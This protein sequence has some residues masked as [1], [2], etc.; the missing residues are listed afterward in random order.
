MTARAVYESQYRARRCRAKAYAAGRPVQTWDIVE[1]VLYGV[2]FKAANN[3]NR[4]FS[5]RLAASSEPL[6]FRI[7]RGWPGHGHGPF[8]GGRK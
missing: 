7:R 1:D 8:S 4:S 5:A 3:A 6:P 2:N